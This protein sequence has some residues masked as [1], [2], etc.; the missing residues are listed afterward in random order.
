MT[1]RNPTVAGRTLRPSPAAKASAAALTPKEVMGMI[2]RHVWLVIFTTIVGVAAGGGGWYAIRRYLPL[3][4]A[5]AVIKVLPP[6]ETDP[7]QV[8]ASQVQQDIQY[9]HRVSLANLM[10]LQSNL[11]ELI[12]I[13]DKV[14]GTKWF[15]Q[16]MQG[17][18]AE[19]VRSLDKHLSASPQREAEQIVVSMTCASPTEAAL[20][21]NEMAQ[22]FVSQHGEMEKGNV[23]EK[24]VELTARQS[25]VER[26]IADSER[27]LDEVRAKT[28]ISDLD[29]TAGRYFQHT[30]TLRLN[31]LEQQE[32]EMNLSIKQL[33]ADIENLQQLAQGPITEQVEHAIEQD[34]VMVSLAQQLAVYQSQLSGRLTKF[35]ENHRVVRQTQEQIDRIEQE[36]AQRRTEIADQ[37]R[38]AN[39]MNARDMLRTLQERL[40]ELQKLRADAQEQQKALDDARSQY[41]QRLRIRDERV[42]MLTQIKTQVEKLRIMLDDPE[43]PKVQLVGLAPDPL[44]MVVSRNILLWGPGG[45]MLGLILGLSLAFLIEMLNDLVR[46]PSDV[47]RFLRIPLLAVIPDAGEDRAVDDIDTCRVVEQAPYSLLGESYRRCRTNLELSSDAALKTLL[48]AS[49]AAG[50]GRTSVACNLASAFVAKFEKVLLIDANLRLPSL[51]LVYPQGASDETAGAQ[52]GVTSVLKGECDYHAAICPSGVEGLDVLYAGPPAANPAE[53]LASHRMKELIEDVVGSYDRVIIDS[54]PVLLVSDV[55]MLARLVSATLLVF[56]AATTK[57]GAAER[58]IRELQDVG[59]NVIG[60]V[61]FGAEAMKGGYFRQQFKA[62]RRYLKRQL[63][64]SR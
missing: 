1:S 40:A 62:Y 16:T 6:V 59:A 11:Q 23:S 41:D 29:R 58:T 51:H 17:D 49:G 56:N 38:R 18:A 32:S 4:K 14:R 57:R 13:S 61:L 47:R 26:E 15:R 64:A 36:R 44:E 37:T 28:G 24:L 60:C 39:L 19:A 8:V 20:I 48:V 43:T 22:L 34:P 3:Y 5:Q 7:M 21:V 10:K 53:L 50:D 12:R 54:P 35:G 27:A 30:I 2:R 31:D 63:A 9:G 25:A 33:Q 46:T 42:E 55:K 45:T 52:L